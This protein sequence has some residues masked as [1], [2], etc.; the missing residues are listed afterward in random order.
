MSPDLGKQINYIIQSLKRMNTSTH[1]E[2]N[3]WYFLATGKY[4]Y[5]RNKMCNLC[6]KRYRHIASSGRMY[7]FCNECKRFKDRM[8]RLKK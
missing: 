7:T 5:E 4:V 8:R 2:V 3:T 6:Y 1:I